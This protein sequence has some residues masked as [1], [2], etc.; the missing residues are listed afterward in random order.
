MSWDF[1]RH[2]FA[3]RTSKQASTARTADWKC[4]GPTFHGNGFGEI[5]AEMR[6][7]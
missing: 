5:R 2:P 4:D 7:A 1:E 3:L 6:E